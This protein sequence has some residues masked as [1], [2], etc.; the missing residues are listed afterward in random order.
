MDAI[1]AV[2]TAITTVAKVIDYFKTNVAGHVTDSSLTKLTKLTRA[3]PLTIISNDCANLEN[4]NDILQY[5]LNCYVGYIVQTAAI[6]GR[7]NSIET[8]RILDAINPDRDSTGLLLQGRFHND[9]LA[10]ENATYFLRE[11]YQ[12][13]LPTR[14]RVIA[15]SIAAME[16]SGS[17][18]EGDT[19]NIYE[20]PN[21]AV[22]K[23]INL[24]IGVD[25][26]DVKIP[27]QVTL[28]PAIL[29]TESL[30]YLFTHRKEDTSLV[31]RYH[32]WRAGRIELIRDMIFGSDL[33]REYRRASLKDKTGTLQEIV[34]RANNARAFGLLTKNPSLAIASNMYVMTK[35]TAAAI[36][37]KTG[38]RFSSPQGREKL[39]EGT[40]AM[41]IAIVEPEWNMVTVYFNGIAQPSTF[42]L[43]AL[44]GKDKGPDMGDVMRSLL[45]GR[46]PAF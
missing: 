36:E 30:T 12:Y 2:N 31:E 32:S 29:P 11:N 13:A 6:L 41:I 42:S 4:L 8:V 17:V 27:M 9:K 37:A 43:K 25:D 39:L 5:L 44:K 16:G 22:G 33:I 23:L 7:V 1:N 10:A 14:E 34:R 21:L 15:K 3:E 45:E 20:M 26:K 24:N 35:D 46:A 18:A 28:A 40:Y 38:Q 19:K